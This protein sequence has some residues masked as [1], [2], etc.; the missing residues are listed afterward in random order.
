LSFVDEY[1][2]FDFGRSEPVIAGK[3]REE[4]AWARGG[5]EKESG[6]VVLHKPLRV[7]ARLL[8]KF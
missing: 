4:I 7:A 8:H 1:G 6:A 2:R 5:A 3:Y